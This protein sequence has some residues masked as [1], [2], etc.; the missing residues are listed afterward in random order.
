MAIHGKE[1]G[2][3]ASL[4]AVL[5]EIAVGRNRPCYLLCGD[6]EYRIQNA[7]ER[8][9][10]ALI[11]DPQDRD[12]NLTVM[13]GEREDSDALCEL[14]ITSPLLPGR[15]VVVVRQTRLLQSRNTLGP[16]IGRIRERLD[17]DPARAARDF[18]HFLEI[19]GLQLDDLQDGGWRRIDDETW[20][21]IVPDEGAEGREGWL[22]RAV[23]LCGG[24]GKGTAGEGPGETDRL[25]Q[26]L[27]GGM[28]EGNCLILTAETVD[29]RKRLFKTLAT[30]G[31]VLAFEKISGEGRLKEQARQQAVQEL[32]LPVLGRHGKRL[33]AEAWAA[34]GM[35]TGFE[36]RESLGAVEK[37]IT[38]TGRRAQIEAAD[39]EA[40]VGRT[41][42]D[43]VFALT[44]A[45]SD[46]DLPAALAALA[47]L[48]DRGDPPLRVFAM[49]A[50][51]LRLLLQAKLLTLSGRIGT[52][53]PDTDY[54]RFQKSVL[55]V[56][57]QWVA[58][59]GESVAIASLHPFVIHQ[60]LRK[61][62]RFSRSELEAALDLLVRTD[63]ALK[64]TGR[65][66]RLLLERVLIA[67]CG[68]PSA[69]R[70][71]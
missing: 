3:V 41:K 20:K 1:P 71:R 14:L 27:G 49:I 42:E 13:D 25:E 55:P 6:E 4:E 64:S 37:L 34:L 28:P 60:L 50:R 38:Y 16:L 44:G 43:S 66:P 17:S 36:L 12:L 63:L 54:A 29:R 57:K 9:I 15:K 45:L 18:L 52:F 51:E 53:Q 47:A 33:S 30:V 59:M 69:V 70:G 7:L 19:T 31:H 61:A 22:P 5:A 35:K 62:Q 10:A 11:P 24:L 46:R 67:V 32:A 40:V 65:D 68:S 56:V 2:R 48:L 21:R 8:I 58:A 39:V 26:T 23:E